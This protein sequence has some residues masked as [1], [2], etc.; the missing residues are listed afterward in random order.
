MNLIRC[1]LLSVVLLAPPAFAA[2]FSEVL[3]TAGIATP[4]GFTDMSCSDAA[5]AELSKPERS[6]Y[7]S[8]EVTRPKAYVAL[9]WKRNDFKKS[10]FQ[11]GI[12]SAFMSNMKLAE[13]VRASFDCAEDKAYE[14]KN[15]LKPVKVDC[16]YRIPGR[17]T[18]YTS[19]L[20]LYPKALKSDGVGLV[21]VVS[22]SSKMDTAVQ[23]EEYFTALVP[24][25][26]AST[27]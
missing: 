22:S 23:A 2:S 6:W 25:S 19:L 20:Y 8:C 1:A 7:T 14:S 13:G 18:L 16:E 26:K 21:A 27:Q 15:S 5:R 9:A 4:E 3:G 24:R 17:P 10:D 11:A 12:G